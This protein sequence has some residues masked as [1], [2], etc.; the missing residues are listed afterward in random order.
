MVTENTKEPR[1]EKIKKDNV[2]TAV[3]EI[4]F[5]YVWEWF[6][7]VSITLL[8]YILSPAPKGK[9]IHCKIIRQR[10]GLD[11]LFPKYELYLESSLDQEPIEFLLYARKRK[12]SKNSNYFISKSYLGHESNKDKEGYV[13]KLRSNFIGTSFVVFDDGFNPAKGPTGSSG[14]LSAS[15]RQE[16]ASVLYASLSSCS[17]LLILILLLGNQHFGIQRS[18]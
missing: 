6:D 9:K 5:K 17:T 18:S 13:G 8:I 1:N 10:N 16:L 14:N 4:I 15:P 12:K 11:S 2:K 3:D 7:T